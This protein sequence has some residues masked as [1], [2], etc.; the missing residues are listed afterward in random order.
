MIP[1]LS[2]SLSSL[3]QSALPAGR[4]VEPEDGGP[5]PYWLS[6][7]PPDPG[8][9]AWL[10]SRHPESGLWPLLLSGLSSEES[11]PWVDGEVFPADMSS[12]EHHDVAELLAGWWAG[13]TSTDEDGT[14]AVTAPFG[15]NWPGLAPPGVQTE[16]P[17]ELADQCADFLADGRTRLGLVPAVRSADTLAVAGWSGPTN[18]TGDAG[19]ISAVLRSWE[20]RFGVRVVGVGFATLQLSVAAPPTSTGHA[21]AVAAEHF[22]FC[23][24][25]V[26]QGAETL[27]AYA[28]QILG[29][30]SWSFWWD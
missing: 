17:D 20:D 23:P 14:S 15:R 28:E 12:P 9:W 21:L 7:A 27:A 6:D 24:D 13:C 26:W 19:E 10:R 29:V 11:R 25:N 30:R 22:A 2:K 8:L 3:P 18:H 5:P 4:M 16:Q 1:N